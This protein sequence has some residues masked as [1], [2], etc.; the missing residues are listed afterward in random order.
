MLF[1]SLAVRPL[2]DLSRD[3]LHSWFADGMTEALVTDLGRISALRVTSLGAVR[4]LKDTASF[5]GMVRELHVDAVVEGGVQRSG[6]RVR[7]DVRLIDAASGYQLWADRFEESDRDRFVLE[8]RVRRGIMAALKAPVTASEK[9]SLDTP[10]TSVPDAYD[11]YL[12]GKLG[13]RKVTPAHLSSAIEIG[14]ASCR[15]RV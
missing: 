14:R 12:R 7:V 4:Q 1:R 5:R 6:D 13:A 3:T 2:A 15:E 8:D 9:R 10:P 11:L